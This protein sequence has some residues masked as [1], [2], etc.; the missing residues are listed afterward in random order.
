MWVIM[1]MWGGLK[2]KRE[3]V[4]RCNELGDVGGLTGGHGDN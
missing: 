3:W 1:W 2:N 4:K